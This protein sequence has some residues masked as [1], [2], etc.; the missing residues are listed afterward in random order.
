M[1]FVSILLHGYVIISQKGVGKWAAWIYHQTQFRVFDGEHDIQKQLA[2]LLHVGA[3]H[4][5]EQ[6]GAHFVLHEVGIGV[7]WSL[8]DINDPVELFFRRKWF[9][10]GR[11]D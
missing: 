5:A 2:H 3:H 1:V 7:L 11:L 8:I 9:H 6:L 10:G 4:V